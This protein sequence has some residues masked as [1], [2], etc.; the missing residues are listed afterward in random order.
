MKLKAFSLPSLRQLVAEV[1][2]VLRV[3]TVEFGQLGAVVGD[4]AGRL[5]GEVAEDIAAEEIALGFE[6]LVFVERL[7][8]G[9]RG[10]G[11][12]RGTHAKDWSLDLWR[13]MSRKRGGEGGDGERVRRRSSR[14]KWVRSGDEAVRSSAS[15]ADLR[16]GRRGG[17]RGGRARGRAGRPS[18]SPVP[19][20]GTGEHSTA[21]EREIVGV[22]LA[23]HGGGDE[24]RG[25][26]RSEVRPDLR[27]ARRIAEFGRGRRGA[28][29]I[30]DDD[31]RRHGE[32]RVAR[33]SG[34]ADA[35]GNDGRESRRGRRDR[36]CEGEFER[37][38]G[39]FALQGSR[40]RR[41]QRGADRAL[42]H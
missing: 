11:S 31:G 29:V 37:R 25:S 3:D 14:V 16:R 9:G 20:L 34:F 23:F 12:G 21:E 24:R 19:K 7:A 15:V 10:G 33:I 41:A 4:A 13:E 42:R 35:F 30:D 18:T 26:R 5:V 36:R 8:G 17:R 22:F 38:G 27:V 1:A 40:G 39:Q 28:A 2:V 6:E 32:E